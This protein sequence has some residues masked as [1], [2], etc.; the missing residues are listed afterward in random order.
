[1]KICVLSDAYEGSE[2]PLVEV[3]QVCDPSPY[4]PGHECEHV[5]LRKAT[6]VR[7]LIQLARR[8]YDVFFNLCDGAWDEDRPGIEVVQALERLDCAFTGADARFYEPS[9]EAMKRVCHAWGVGT[10][11]AVTARDEAGVARAARELRFPLIVKHP[12]SYSSIGLTPDSRVETREALEREAEKMIAAFGGALLEEFVAGREFSVLVAE[13]PD[14]PERPTAYAPVEIVFPP[15]ETFKHFDLKWRF[16]E[17]MDCVPCADELLGERLREAGRRLF[18]GLGGAGYGRCDVRV[19]ERGDI[20]MLEINPNCAV[21]YPPEDPGTADL[22]LAQDPAGHRGFC[23][24]VVR[25]ALARRERRRRPWEVRGDRAGNYSMVAARPIRAGEAIEVYEER[26]HYLVTRKHVEARWGERERGWFSR[27]AWPLSD[28]VWSI[29]S[30]DPEEWRPINHSC[31]PTAW[32]RGLDVVARRD[33]APGEEVTLDYATFCT[34]PMQEFNCECGAPSCRGV[35]RAS[36]HLEPA[37]AR[38]AGHL[39]DHV[40]RKRRARRPRR[41]SAR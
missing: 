34:E 24:Q 26:A 1:V 12:S 4:L 16:Y 5:F 15:G 22:I 7:D 28:E 36:D 27:Y 38:Y 29:W 18:L 10:P 8:G 9:R 37:V 13:D 20:Y 40:R 17:G 19:D 14:R 23:A 39:S 3:D 30:P 41:A 11:P 32:L 31:E 21:F 25:A 2:S 6:A 33:L 35:V